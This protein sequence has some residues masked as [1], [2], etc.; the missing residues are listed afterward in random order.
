MNTMIEL[1]DINEEN[2]LS[3][4]ELEVDEDQK[5]QVAPNSNSIA[6]GNYTK[7]AWFKGI[8]KDGKPVGFIMFDLN[9]TTNKCD[10]WRF[11]IDKRYQGLGYGKIALKKAIEYVKS[12]NVFREINSSFVL[13]E[14]KNAGDFYKNL[15]FVVTGRLDDCDEIGITYKLEPKSPVANKT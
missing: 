5:D 10:L 15:G 13:K 14:G 4:I 9:T 6:Q 7:S 2:L 12:L 1:R 8:F 3:I 11:M